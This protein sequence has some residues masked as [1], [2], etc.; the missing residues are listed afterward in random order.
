MFTLLILGFLSLVHIDT[1]YFGATSTS[2]SY[3][4]ALLI[5][6]ATVNP[7]ALSF[8][9]SDIASTYKRACKLSFVSSFISFT[10][11]AICL[12]SGIFASP[13]TS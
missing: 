7:T 6:T 13:I 4:C 3:T 11:P 12:N 2:T 10:N 8:S 1:V 5:P 9:S